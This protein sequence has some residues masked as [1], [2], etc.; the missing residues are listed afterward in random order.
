MDNKY[1]S[2]L[3]QRSSMKNQVYFPI[4][5]NLLE[6]KNVCF[7]SNKAE[8]FEDSFVR[9]GNPPLPRPPSYFKKNLFNINITL[10]NC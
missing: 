1:F 9:E 10:S 2:E 5:R 7:N 4:V 8:P 6:G 3:L